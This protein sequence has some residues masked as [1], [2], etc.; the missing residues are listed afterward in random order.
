MPSSGHACP[1]PPPPTSCRGVDVDV[2]LG[3][4]ALH[5]AQVQRLP[6][7][8]RRICEGRVLPM[9]QP[10]RACGLVHAQPAVAAAGA[11]GGEDG[12]GEV[13]RV[14]LQQRWVDEQATLTAQC[15]KGVAAWRSA[16]LP[17]CLVYSHSSSST[18]GSIARSDRSP[19]VP[20]H[21]V[22]HVGQ[23]PRV[24]L[25]V[26]HLRHR[27]RCRGTTQSAHICQAGMRAAAR[28]ACPV[29]ARRLP[30]NIQTLK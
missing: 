20:F 24:P 22:P 6:A 3:Q 15:S 13:G 25:E 29:G 23:Q 2:W 7:L 27:G 10:R 19:P 8:Q 18:C 14:W 1:T 30:F 4:R 26:V 16:S 28:Q 12:V 21:A 17:A 11:G 9:L 5:A